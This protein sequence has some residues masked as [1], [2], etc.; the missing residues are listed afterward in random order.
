MQALSPDPEEL[1][2]ISFFAPE[3]S[4]MQENS[5]RDFVVLRGTD[6]TALVSCG[7][8][9]QEP[10]AVLCWSTWKCHS[11]ALPAQRTPGSW[12]WQSPNQHFYKTKVCSLA[13]EQHSAPLEAVATTGNSF[14]L[15]VKV[16]PGSHLPLHEGLTQKL[17]IMSHFTPWRDL[18]LSMSQQI[19]S[20]SVGWARSPALSSPALRL[21]LCSLLLCLWNP[22]C[23]AQCGAWS[24]MDGNTSGMRGLGR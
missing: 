13:G 16:S 3:A 5:M 20:S 18:A 19:S 14:L 24:R 8:W 1:P 21:Q 10:T 22:A 17:K 6:H 23:R 11:R 9:I 4:G 15:L 12:D 7:V 2:E